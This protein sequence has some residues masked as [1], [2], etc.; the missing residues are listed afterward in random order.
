ITETITGVES[1]EEREYDVIKGTSKPQATSLI[2]LL[3]YIHDNGKREMPHIEDVVVYRALDYMK[4]DFYAKRNLELTESIRLKSKKGTLL[5]LMDDTKTPMGA[6]R[7][8]QWIDRPLIKQHDIEQRLNAVEQFVNG[9]IERDEL[10]SYLNMVYDIERLV[11]R[12]SY[13]NVNA[14]DLVQLNYSIKQI[15]Y[16]KEIIER[17]DSSSVN[18]FKALEPLEDL[19]ELLEES[20]VEDPPLSVKEGGLFKTGYNAE[21]D[22]FKE[23][24]TNGKQWIA[25]L[26]LKERERTGVK[27]LKVSFNKVLGYYIE[28]TKAKLNNVDTE[29]LGYQR[30]QTLS[31]DERFVTEELKEKESII[32]GAEDKAIEL[33]YQIFLELRQRIKAYTEKLQAQAKLLSEIDCLQSFAEIAQK[34]HYTRPLF[35]EDK[36]LSLKSSRHPV[37]ERVMDHNDYVP[38][39]C[40]LNQDGFIYLITGPNMSGK[41]TYM[42]QIAIIS[43]MAQMGAYVP[44]DYALLPIFDQIFTRIGAADDLVSGKSTFM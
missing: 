33:E 30:K 42:R 14:K 43:I 32:I 38:N 34:Y 11:G 6:R 21:L 24:S 25:E 13:G 18:R 41:S 3:N 40:Y 20:L 4:M 19:E 10:R 16:I 5:W 35:S 27:S 22:K 39:D 23:A 15:P 17:L 1:Y 37:V 7:L 44:E 8:K 28:I 26:Q 12:V 9:F 29:A 2:Y 31:N 36:T